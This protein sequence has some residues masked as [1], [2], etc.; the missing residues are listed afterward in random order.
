[1]LRAPLSYPLLV[2]N[3]EQ[4]VRCLPAHTASE[5]APHTGLGIEAYVQITSPL[6]RFNDCMVHRQLLAATHGYPPPYTAETMQRVGER[7]FRLEKMST[8][9]EDSWNRY[10]ILQRMKDLLAQEGNLTV[11]GTIL[12]VA[13]RGL[14]RRYKVT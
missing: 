3:W 9:F 4:L 1:M 8:K 6:R 12:E 11:Y 2:H 5:A 7:C 13:I 10:I 14:V